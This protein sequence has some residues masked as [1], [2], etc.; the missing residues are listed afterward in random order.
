[1]LSE[2]KFSLFAENVA[3]C[4]CMSHWQQQVPDTKIST[5]HTE[6][7]TKCHS[8]NIPFYQLL[9]IC[10]MSIPLP[11]KICRVAQMLVV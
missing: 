10:A 7:I 5:F 11:L 2:R 6:I 9:N 8:S 3:V 1:M 4:Y